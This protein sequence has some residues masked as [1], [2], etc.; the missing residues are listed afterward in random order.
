MGLARAK[1]L[2]S[3]GMNMFIA[4]RDRRG[5]MPEIEQHFDEIRSCGVCFCSV[6]TDA[7]RSENQGGIVPFE[8]PPW[9]R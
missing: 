2:A 6:N 1:K 3:G 7:L 4:H 9:S 8:I 5:N